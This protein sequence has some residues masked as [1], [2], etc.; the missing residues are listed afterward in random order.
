MPDNPNNKPSTTVTPAPTTGNSASLSSSLSSVGNIAG[1]LFNESTAKS[2]QKTSQNTQTSGKTTV[3]NQIPKNKSLVEGYSQLDSKTDA[4]QVFNSKERF[5]IDLYLAPNFL[6]NSNRFSTKSA[7]LLKWLTDVKQLFIHEKLFQFGITGGA[8]VLDNNGN[9]TH[10]LDQ[11]ISY[12]LVIDICQQINDAKNILRYEPYIMSIVG[13]EELEQQPGGAKLLQLKFEDIIS[14]E[15][16]RHSIGTLLK[17]HND[18]KNTA[19]FPELYTIIYRYLTDF[20][21]ENSGGQ[22]TYGKDIKF[23][24]YKENDVTSIIK[25]I[26][27]T[28]EPS[29]SIYDLITEINK[30]ACIAIYPDN[31][32]TQNFEMIGDV[33]VPL[34]FREEY[35]DMLN[36]YYKLHKEQP[37]N[38]KQKRGNTEALFVPRPFT[39]RSF[40]A[41]FVAAFQGKDEIVF[42][43]FTTSV[44]NDQKINIMTLNGS[45]TLPIKNL[46]TLSS[47]SNL[48]A[49][50]WK[51]VSF[52]SSN[53]QGGANRLVYFN[54]I[55]EFFNQ[56][57]LRNKLDKDTIK[58]SNVVPNFYLS[59]QGNEQ[60]SNDQDL[61]ERNSNIILIRN[62]KDDPL[63][64]ILM[65]IGKCIASLVFLNN[66]YSFEV[67]GNLLRRPNEVVNLYTPQQDA[68]LS[69]SQP[70]RTDLMRSNNVML[71]VTEVIHNFNN[72]MFTDKVI[73]NRIYEQV[74]AVGK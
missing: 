15:A 50:R 21:Y 16:K 71:Y 52:I 59:H 36:Y 53:A 9:L 58:L 57:F 39:L 1:S 38:F 48:T 32:V 35:P 73:C 29:K 11:F 70:I 74:P 23:N 2:T 14:A 54:W 67:Q 43:S 51:N 72:N 34:F 37:E 26:F 12:D 18:L 42:E 62:E 8:V 47:N 63:K 49:T 60:L 7:I 61:A 22:F 31:T 13:V 3:N 40:Y 4:F 5:Q 33:M 68:K 25:M 65:Q 46:Q 27:D 6:N 30:Y 64:E 24:H 28:I 20:I 44:T 41:P 69:P 56:A 66:L 19:S 17:F 10:L 55:Y 45:N